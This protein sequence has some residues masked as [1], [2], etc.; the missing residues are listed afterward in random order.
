MGRN[1][2]EV[3]GILT[4]IGVVLDEKGKCDEAV[5]YFDTSLEITARIKGKNSIDTT[6]Q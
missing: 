1:S 6:P 5:G 4:K 3:A 2:L